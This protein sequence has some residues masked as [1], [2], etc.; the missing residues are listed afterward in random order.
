MPKSI[1]RVL[2]WFSQKPSKDSISFYNY[3][4]FIYFVK[5]FQDRVQ[6]VA[7]SSDGFNFSSC[8]YD[9]KILDH[10]LKQ[11]SQKQKQKNHYQQLIK[12][13]VS[14]DNLDNLQIQAMVPINKGD[15]VIYHYRSET[16]IIKVSAFL[17]SRNLPH[18][19]LWFSLKP[20]WKAPEKWSKHDVGFI[21]LLPV[22][23]KLIAYWFVKGL[24][25]YAA[26]YPLF[27]L[28]KKLLIKRCF[29]NKVKENP[30]ISPRN[31]NQWEAF[32]TFNPAAVYINKKVHIL[33][34]AQGHDYFSSLG[35]ANSTDGINIDQRLDYPVFKPTQ[36]FE[37]NPTG[38]VNKFFVS[39]GGYGGCEDPRITKIDNRLYMTYVAF[40]GRHPPR[41]ALTS[42]ALQDFLNQK[43]LW[44]KP[45]LISPP[46]VVDK[47][48][49]I[50]P[51]KIKGKYVI[52]HRIFPNILIDFVDSLD[53]DGSWFLPGKYKIPPRSRQWWD[54]RKIG[55]GSPPI[56]T[57]HGWL[58]IYQAV[59]DKDDSQYKIGA[60]LLDLINPAKV[61][62]RSSRPILEPDQKYEYE[63]FKA[64]VVYPCGAVI[65]KKTLFV[66]YGAADSYVSVATAN[67]DK[68]LDG[69]IKDKTAR[70]YPA[71]FK[72]S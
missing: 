18:K 8:K 9:Q 39:G 47:S 44:Q 71:H 3:K 10:F 27:K 51:E 36:A 1:H 4:K 31:H 17:F 48:C 35:Y 49:C 40:D 37:K 20:I 33:Y 59:D 60:M 11:Q 57:K 21:D 67:L 68:F 26:S 16:N 46:G 56:K 32:T 55:A 2:G 23:D 72:L 61:L 41:I 22:K 66:Y 30:I 29:L 15:L 13:H 7:K 69:L 65:I 43:W 62:H 34:R 52:F 42:I 19:L 6:L 25:I 54:S 63:G 50:L 28:G 64:G 38:N 24:G 45:V 58:L 53:F 14:A 12:A 5:R 70:V